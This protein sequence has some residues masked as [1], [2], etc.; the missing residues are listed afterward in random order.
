MDSLINL[1]PDHPLFKHLPDDTL[2]NLARGAIK[3]TY[4]SQE[5]IV[6]QEDVWPYLFYLAKGEI[7]AVKQSPE[8]RTFIATTLKPFDVFW[9][10]SFFIEGAP[11]PVYLQAK[12]DST[13]YIWNREDLTP[14]IKENGIMA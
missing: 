7:N 8:G 3:K 13:I 6:H 5:I 4:T 12:L 2:D 9:G 1:L 14:I 11:M 10:L